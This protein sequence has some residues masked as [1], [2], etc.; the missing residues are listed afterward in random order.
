M[1]FGATVAGD[2]FQRKFD[3]CFGKL[4]QVI[5]ITEDI[6]FVEYKPY[7]SD[8][9]QAFTNL[10]QTTQ[11]CKVKL[12]F[13]KLQYKLNEL[14]FFGETYRTSHC[15]PARSKLSAITAMPSPANKKQVQ[16]FIGMINYLSKFLPGF[17]EL[18]EPIKKLSKHKVPLIWDLNICAR[19]QS[20]SQHVDAGQL[21]VP[22]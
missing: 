18:A 5:I 9:D 13:D 3:E 14:D 7:H 1:P 12:N 22:L 6:M 17:S 19:V 8:H 21:N 4:Q 2:V 11:R 15:K 16:S 10:L 20:I